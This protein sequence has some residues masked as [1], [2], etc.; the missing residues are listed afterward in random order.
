MFW[1]LIDSTFEIYPINIIYLRKP[2]NRI[3]STLESPS[4]DG[5]SYFG[6]SAT[7][8]LEMIVSIVIEWLFPHGGMQYIKIKEAFVPKSK[9]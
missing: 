7:I 5:E 8:F 4:K 9:K 1:D 6:F 2:N 3:M